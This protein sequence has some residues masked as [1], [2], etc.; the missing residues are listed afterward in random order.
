[1]P[2]GNRNELTDP[3]STSY[4]GT[5]ARSENEGDAYFQSTHWKEAIDRYEVDAYARVEVELASGLRAFVYAGP[6]LGDG[7]V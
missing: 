6:P 4:R 3:A 7:A 2:G 5:A 1:M